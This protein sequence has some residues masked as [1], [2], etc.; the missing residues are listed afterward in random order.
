M[1]AFLTLLAVMLALPL[2]A[3]NLIPNSSFEVGP[4]R[5]P[6]TYQ[7]ANNPFMGNSVGIE[8][9][10]T[11]TAVHG[12]FAML[13]PRAAVL[14]LRP[15]WLTNGSYMQT[16]SVRNATGSSGLAVGGIATP[17]IMGDHGQSIYATMPQFTAPAVWARVTNSIT[18]YSNG[19]YTPA[20]QAASTVGADTPAFVV[21]AI[22]LEPGTTATAYAPA[23]AIEAGLFVPQ[24]NA[25]YYSDSV[26]RIVQIKVRNE[27][28]TSNAYYRYR[29]LDLWNRTVASNTIA[30]SST[31]GD[32]TTHN[33]SLPIT[34]GYLRMWGRLIHAPD[35]YDEAT[36]AIFPWPSNYTAAAGSDWLG[37]HPNASQYS[38]QKEMRV[39][40]KWARTLS[41]DY[42]V[43]RWSTAEPTEGNYS[44]FDGY[45]TNLTEAGMKVIVPLTDT[46]GSWPSW[47]SATEATL[48]AQW[49]T[50][51][52]N[53]VYRYNHLLGLS[54]VVWYEIGPNEPFQTGPTTKLNV[55]IATNYAKA[56]EYA[57]WGMSNYP[58]IKLVAIAGAYG[59]G[60]WAWE[61]WTNLSVA[62]RTYVSAI[63]THIY[64]QQSQ[65]ANGDPNFYE[66]GTFS[67]PY[68]WIDRFGS[69]GKEIWN[70]ESAAYGITG[71]K[72]LNMMHPVFFP[73]YSTLSVEAQR[74]EPMTRQRVEA[75]RILVTAL[76]DI[77]V[78]FDR[79]IYYDSRM[80]SKDAIET[81]QPYAGDQLG[82]DRPELV[83]L[84]IATHFVKTGHGQLTNSVAEMYH[85]TSPQSG[86]TVA[87]WTYNRTNASF[88]TTNG[89]F[90]I[91]DAMG[92]L[93][94][95]NQTEF[96]MDS[97]PRYFVTDTLTVAQMSNTFRYAAI[98]PLGETNAP[99]I[100]FDV[101]PTANW[102]GDPAPTLVKWTGVG[103]NYYS[104]VVTNNNTETN[105]VFSWKLD[106][107]S[108][109]IFSASNHT[110]LANLSAGNHTFYVRARDR[111]GNT[112]TNEYTFGE[113]TPPPTPPI[114]NYT[115]VVVNGAVNVNGGIFI[116]NQ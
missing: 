5:G 47:T 101:A 12:N 2:G 53:I 18:I 93:I 15:V 74:G 3:V 65:D 21:D 107:G 37:G 4:G 88:T 14:L 42:A 115:A 86:A 78:G 41:P 97:M 82:Y 61:A 50:Y 52:S 89:F 70:S 64:P 100:S 55:Q 31:G 20:F 94:S 11:N 112:R 7:N 76:K 54:N 113:T 40:R 85:F 96:I 23:N 114:S 34:N 102:S 58:G 27:G 105:V 36:A 106:S 6:V 83:A 17:Y 24:T 116:R 22:Q 8:G 91:Y 32:T 81:S 13:V 103:G 66:P 79:F 30:I 57:I 111:A 51:C 84:S 108:W 56:M 25:T 26:S 87:G 69:S 29:I 49:R 35:S 1:R 109:S 43:A 45:L 73:Y 59:N 68:G 48:L 16:F 46:D 9:L 63:S 62:A 44:F 95:S 39:N 110:W 92:N 98:S 60:D 10:I 77:G 71:H 19:Y 90:A 33:E 75:M 38:V 99:Y 28:T 72:G 80:F 67:N 104:W